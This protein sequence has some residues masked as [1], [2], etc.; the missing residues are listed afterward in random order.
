MIDLR[1]DTVTRPSAAMLQAMVAAPLGDDVMGDDPT[2]IRL[3]E[4]VAERAGKAAGLFFPSGTQSNLGA[5]MA[6]CERGDEYLVGQLAHTY[7]YEG[8]GAAVLGSIQPQPVEHAAD[9][10]LPLEKLAAALKPAG[11]AHFAR[12][13]LLALENTFHG[14]LIP[15]SYV[16]AAT[17]WA[18]QHGL[19]THLD[20]ARVF[21]AAVASG[22]PL[23]DMCQPFDSVSICFSKG[24]GAPVGSVLV[25]SAELIA[26]A[27][28]WRKMLGG[29]L[30]QAGVLAAAC[31]YAL[32]HN[33]DRL[34][35]DHAN[36]RLLAEG[37]GGIAGVTV[38]SQDTNMVFVQV[39]PAL[40][41]GLTA[42]LDAQNIKMRAVYGGP[43][44][45]VTHLDISADDVRRAVRAVADYCSTAPR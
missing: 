14:K 5:L 44:R 40:C 20:G 18:R 15:A 34:A 25:G 38:L 23:A 39:E 32:E 33:V 43:T 37:L 11:D 17:D 3:Q 2:V 41:D 35:E 4:A 45:L 13:R 22:K 29:G 8:G 31:L 10:S 24:L 21:N 1:S 27:H 36:A 42:A 16:Q 7:K 19:A 9:G 30:R 26:R 28:R 6:H 12:T